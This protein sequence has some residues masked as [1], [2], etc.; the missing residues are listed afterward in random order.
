MKCRF[1]GLYIYPGLPNA[2]SV[3]QETD[4]NYGPFKGV[5]RDNLK[6]MSSAFY[7]AGLSIPL[8][9]TTF[10]LIVYGGTIPVGPSTTITCRNALAETFDV[11]S[12][13]T[14]WREVGAVPH[15][16]KCL[17][18]SKVRHDGTDERDPN[19]DAYQDIQPQ[20]DYSTAQLNLMGYRGDVLRAQFCPDKISERKESMAVTVANTRE[21]QEAIAAANTHG[22]K[23]FVTG[24][25]HMTSNDMFKAAEINRRKVEAAEREKEK[26]RRVEFHARREAALP[27]VNR[28]ELELENDVGRL[29]S[30]E[31]EVLLRW[32]G[33]AASKMGNVANRRLLY[34]QFAEGDIVEEVSIPAPWT[35]IDEAELVALR[36]AP[37]EMYDTAYGRF[38]EQ[39]KR[40][41]ER[42]YQKMSAAEKD[43]FKKKMAE[44]DEADAGVDEESPPPTPTPV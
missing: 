4:H 36:D 40:D 23:F 25:E 11:E 24:G 13:L 32:K 35:D 6:K 34:Q 37:I 30:K 27:I 2:T 14:S 42:S 9:T 26:K 17:T 43:I 22:A 1:R 12:N 38:E 21:R 5:V 7:A 18:N 29:T 19:F 31:L 10:G 39:K 15:T 16:R 33:V 41:V 44:I 28:L 3:Q 8:N 20:N